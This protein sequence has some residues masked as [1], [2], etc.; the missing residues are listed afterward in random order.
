MMVSEYESRL[1]QLKQKLD[2]NN[3][4][5]SFITSPVNI[6]YLTGFYSE[7]HERLLALVIDRTSEEDS[8]YV[9][10]LD[11][12]AARENET[13]HSII[14]I[15]DDE[16]PFSVIEQNNQ[17]F[18]NQIGI[19]K[20][21]LNVERYENLIKIYP[22]GQFINIEKILTSLRLRKSDSEIK[23]VKQ[24]IKV[25]ENVLE[26][27]LKKVSIGMTENELVAEFE[28]LMRLKGAEA[29]A[30]STIVLAGSN[31][32]LP[33]GTPGDNPIQRGC[34]LLV[35]MG[36][37]VGGY[38]SDISRTFFIGEESKEMKNIYNTV[39]KANE[40]AINA[41]EVNQ[42]LG[43]IDK[44]AR[45]HI[46]ACGYGDYFNNRVGHGLGLEVHEAPSIHEQNQEK[47][48]TGMVF[49][50]EP[51]IYIPSLG[52]VRIEDDVYV[53]ANGDIEI[54]TTFPKDLITL[55]K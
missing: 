53:K 34:P 50:I 40:L 1:A 16:S 7:P 22:H 48:E 31:S 24:A 10:S 27:G 13:I 15:S 35:D 54:L 45:N 55:N 41:V 12:E 26:E 17:T 8:L 18:A 46:H 44:A 9:P 52:G 28:Y 6:Y 43:N 19:E 33:H 42:S 37:K 11:F 49:T 51:G 36:V 39:L 4:N 32:S 38:C 23:Q 29:P 5:L 3:V 25:I 30:F 47:M 14:P 21:E 20:K 2:E